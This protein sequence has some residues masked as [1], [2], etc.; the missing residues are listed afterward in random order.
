MGLRRGEKG[1]GDKDRDKEK[2][3]ENPDQKSEEQN[4]KASWQQMSAQGGEADGGREC[5]RDTERKRKE[6]NGGEK[7][8]L[9]EDR[10]G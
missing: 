4:N 7:E 3:P 6:R 1:G 5:K 8:H 10:W 9:K 2:E